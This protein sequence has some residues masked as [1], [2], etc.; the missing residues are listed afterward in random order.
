MTQITVFEA[1]MLWEGF[2]YQMGC[3]SG[4]MRD[5]DLVY[6]SDAPWRNYMLSVGLMSERRG[7][8]GKVMIAR[9]GPGTRQPAFL[10][11]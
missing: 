8:A 3:H 7:A 6:Q 2:L 9:A 5:R 11:S 1:V 4:V 10:M